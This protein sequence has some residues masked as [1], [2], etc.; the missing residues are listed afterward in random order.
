MPAEYS[1]DRGTSMNLN[2]LSAGNFPDFITPAEILPYSLGQNMMDYSIWPI[3]EGRV[4]V[5][6]YKSCRNFLHFYRFLSLLNI[7]FYAFPAFLDA[8]ECE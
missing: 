8:L 6:H 4:F 2:G 5:E 7:F 3:L 1:R